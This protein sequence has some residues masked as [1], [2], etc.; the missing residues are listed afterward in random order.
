MKQP[1]SPEN[2]ELPYRHIEGS[3]PPEYGLETVNVLQRTPVDSSQGQKT[4]VDKRTSIAENVESQQTAVRNAFFK[5][6]E[7]TI[8]RAGTASLQQCFR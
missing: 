7:V 1:L 4:I 8:E 2:N 5:E 3:P 6:S